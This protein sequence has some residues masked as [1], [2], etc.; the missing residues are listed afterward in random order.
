MNNIELSESSFTNLFS[1]P[2]SLPFGVRYYDDLL[3]DMYDHNF[4]L[5]N[6][7]VNEDKLNVLLDIKK[8][9]N[10]NFIKI[11]TP[12]RS[13]FLEK[14]GFE[15]E[16]LLTMLKQDYDRFDVPSTK[17]VSFKSVKENKR[18]IEE[19]IDIEIK[20]YGPSYGEDF[21]RRRWIRY[22]EKALEDNGL[23][24]Y[25]ALKEDKVVGYCYS[26]Y[27]HNIVCVD[28]LLVVKEMRKQY[29]ASSMLKHIAHQYHCPIMLHA[30]EDE[31]PKEMYKKLG[32]ETKEI[33]IDYLLLDKPKNDNPL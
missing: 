33:L 9:R 26:Y 13:E 6:T 16:A 30:S 11:T 18:Y 15:S 3:P 21:C 19:L 20:Y 10:E 32:F 29:V 17:D 7:L 31:T 8:Q 22:Y 27:S 2:V 4:T 23:D 28:G 24:I 12:I 5:I 25:V 14:K 1:K